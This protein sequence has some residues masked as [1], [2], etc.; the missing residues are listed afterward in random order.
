M[1]TSNLNRWA[2]ALV[3][4]PTTGASDRT[5]SADGLPPGIASSHKMAKTDLQRV[6]AI[7]NSLHQVGNKFD[8]PPAILAALASR[9][10]RCGAVLDSA[11]FGDGGNAFGILQVDQRF[12]SLVDTSDPASLTH[13]EQATQIFVN[14]RQ[15]IQAK[16]P[17]WEDEY[18]L[19]GAAVAYNAGV[20]TVQ[21]KDRID[22]GSTHDDYGSDV[23]ARAQFFAPHL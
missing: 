6:L 9:E 17:T 12:H 16:H 11:G 7:A 5:A 2:T 19:K 23:I 1:V 13:I 20:G 21:T 15:Q 14:F 22:I 18:I 3:N 8:V 10:S 4:A